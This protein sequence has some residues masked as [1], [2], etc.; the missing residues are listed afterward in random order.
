MFMDQSVIRLECSGP[1][2]ARIK[3]WEGLNVKALGHQ[4][5]V[6]DL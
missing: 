6:G 4:R 3:G 2:V 1:I 5:L